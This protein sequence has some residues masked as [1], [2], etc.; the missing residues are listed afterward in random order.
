V[1]QVY[2]PK[3]MLVR[4]AVLDEIRLARCKAMARRREK[5]RVRA[6]RKPHDHHHFRPGLFARFFGEINRGVKHDQ[7]V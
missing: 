5:G 6:V 7:F 3:R 1:F 2:D 4:W